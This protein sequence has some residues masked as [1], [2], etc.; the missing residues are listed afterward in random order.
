MPPERAR[1]DNTQASKAADNRTFSRLLETCQFVLDV[2]GCVVSPPQ[3][4]PKDKDKSPESYLLPGGD[5][6]K[7]CIR[8]RMLHGVARRRVRQ[9]FA[10]EDLEYD[11]A[12][13]GVPI[14]QEDMAAT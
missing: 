8:V 5:G 3:Q 10:R 2:I 13:E 12:T 6:W 9:R 1:E 4:D 14:S 7:A 11:E